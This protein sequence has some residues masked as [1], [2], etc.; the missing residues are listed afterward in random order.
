MYI[1]I[2]TTQVPYIVD[3]EKPMIVS[4]GVSCGWP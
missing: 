3:L 1:P 2:L 4:A